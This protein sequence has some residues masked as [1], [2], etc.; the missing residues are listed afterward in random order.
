MGAAVFYKICVKV[1]QI[2]E[3]ASERGCHTKPSHAK[4]E[5]LERVSLSQFSQIK[6]T[7]QIKH[8]SSE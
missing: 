7:K 4:S 3:H 8:G 5:L 6:Q 2:R 1:S